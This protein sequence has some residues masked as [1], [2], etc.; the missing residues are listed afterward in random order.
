MIKYSWFYFPKQFAGVIIVGYLN[1]TDTPGL[2]GAKPFAPLPRLQ[3]SIV[4]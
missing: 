3:F 2:P 1:M 4:S